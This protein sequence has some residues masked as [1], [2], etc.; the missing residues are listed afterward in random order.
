MEANVI[1]A[2]GK[3]GVVRAFHNSCSHR[4]VALV[5][6]ER[7]NSLTF[8][9]PYHAWMYRVDGSLSAI[10]AE[11]DFPQIDKASNGLSPIHLDIWNGFIFLNFAEEPEVTLSEFLSG[12]DKMLD[13]APFD[14]FPVYMQ[15]TDEI[16]CNWKNLVNAFNE[17]YHVAVLHQKT[18]RPAVIPK[19]KPA[20]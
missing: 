12:L 19:E 2:R 1:I 8:R 17:G 3:D 9:C 20:S 16:D 11:Q 7:G 6:K 18:L 15:V 4:G 13:G 14:Q 10:P 5:C